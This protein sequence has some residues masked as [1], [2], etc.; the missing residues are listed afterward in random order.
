MTLPDTI[1]KQRIVGINYGCKFSG[2]TVI[3]YNTFHEV[4]FLVSSKNAD[5]DSFI[6]NEILHIDPDIVLINAPLSL[7]GV[8]KHLNGYV[9]YFFRKCDSEIKASSPMFAGGLTARAIGLK[10]LLNDFGYPVYETY[11]RKM[12]EILSLPV[13]L[14]KQAITDLDGM[15]DVFMKKACIALNK[16]LITTWNHFDSLLA[17]FSGLRYMARQNSVFGKADEGLV[18]V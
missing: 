5:A 2:T 16:K 6:L 7:P 10:K 13:Q 14:Y 12:A 17:F 4:R 9:D 18:Y 8:Y 11:P 3:C 15:L 1:L